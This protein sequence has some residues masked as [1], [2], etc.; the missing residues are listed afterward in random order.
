VRSVRLGLLLAIVS[1]IVGFIAAALG[2]AWFPALL[3]A[4]A[5]LAVLGLLLLRRD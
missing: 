5:I 2:L 4:A 1:M 3:S